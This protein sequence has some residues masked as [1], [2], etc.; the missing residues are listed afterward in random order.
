MT[1]S[2]AVGVSREELQMK[3]D[4]LIFD[5]CKIKQKNNTVENTENPTSF[6]FL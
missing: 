2:F 1:P 6:S 5:S 4:T 3:R